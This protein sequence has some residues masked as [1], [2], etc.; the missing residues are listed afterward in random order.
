MSQLCILHFPQI[1]IVSNNEEL[2][3]GNADIMDFI[4]KVFIDFIAECID[5]INIHMTNGNK[6]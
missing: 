3:Q 1:A 4:I 5:F 6:T 2:N